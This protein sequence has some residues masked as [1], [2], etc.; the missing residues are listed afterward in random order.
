MIVNSLLRVA[1]IDAGKVILRKK[2]TDINTIIESVARQYQGVIE[3]KKQQLVTTLASHPVYGMVDE[4]YYRMAIENILDNA[5]K[6]TEEGGKIEVSVARKGEHVVVSISDT[7]VG[8]ESDN[9]SLVFEKFHRIHND[10]SHKVAGSGLGLYW[11]DKV[12]DL[13]Q[14]KLDVESEIGKGTTFH[15][16]VPLGGSDA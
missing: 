10:L 1:Q 14:G 3:S 9:L 5:S 7:G 13:H 12:I 6:Y 8:I 2:P 16:Y 4:Q 11:V 15:I